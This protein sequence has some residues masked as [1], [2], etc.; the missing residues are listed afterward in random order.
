MMPFQSKKERKIANTP[1]LNVE[2]VYDYFK[3]QKFSI[4]NQMSAI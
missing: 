4:K 2:I 1:T 3:F